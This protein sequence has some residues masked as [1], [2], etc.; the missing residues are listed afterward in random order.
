MQAQLGNCAL[1]KAE[2]QTCTFMQ[3]PQHKKK[4]LQVPQPSTS[5]LPTP[6]N[7]PSTSRPIVQLEE[8]ATPSAITEDRT[9]V[10]YHETPEH[11]GQTADFEELRAAGSLRSFPSFRTVESNP[12]AKEP[13]CAA[14]RLEAGPSALSLV[15]TTRRDIFAVV[16]PCTSNLLRLFFKIVWPIFPTFDRIRMY[17]YLQNELPGRQTMAAELAIG[18]L[19]AAVLVMATK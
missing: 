11:L 19:I 12:N 8:E 7:N 15:N 5:S 1:C 9:L 6:A 4:P 13:S 2:G 3:G 17:K 16:E 18:P 10:W 14:H